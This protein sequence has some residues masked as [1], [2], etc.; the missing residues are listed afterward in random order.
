VPAPSSALVDAASSTTPVAPS[1]TYVDEPVATPVVPSVVAPSST[2]A[3]NSTI[4]PTG[5]GAPVSPSALPSLTPPVITASYS[6]NPPPSM[7]P[8]TFATSVRPKPTEG[9]STGPLK[10]YFQCGGN[11][12]TGASLCAKGLECKAWNPYYSQCVKSEA[13]QPGPSKGPAAPAQPMPTGAAPSAVAPS[14]IAPQ[15]SK[16]EP[17]AIESPKPV[18]SETPVATEPTE[19]QY[20]LSTF[21]AFLEQKAGTGAA[22]QIRRM[23]AAL[24]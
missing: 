23:I 22:A 16:V 7:V 15:P 4:L 10:E 19:K 21:I 6:A 8:S 17:V 14:A 12:F 18:A 9:A 24:Q 11:G 1:S 13:S 20:T 5:T 3:S 2:G